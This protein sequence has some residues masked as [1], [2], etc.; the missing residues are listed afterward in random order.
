MTIKEAIEDLE[1]RKAF[2]KRTCTCCWDPAIELA[3]VTLKEKERWLSDPYMLL[4]YA[5]ERLHLT[6]NTIDQEVIDIIL[7][8]VKD[9]IDNADK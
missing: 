3:L 4:C 5:L 1:A 7:H 2:L 6:Y 8:M 9:Y